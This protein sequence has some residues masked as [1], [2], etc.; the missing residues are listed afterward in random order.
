MVGWLQDNPTLSCPLSWSLKRKCWGLGKG[1][2]AYR[3]A[4]WSPVLGCISSHWT[5]PIS[6]PS[7]CVQVM[8]PRWELV[9]TSP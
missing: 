9:S 5:L 8:D 2:G 1:F 6:S 7:L 3:P 4:L